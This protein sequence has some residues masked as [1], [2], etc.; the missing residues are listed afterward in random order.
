MLECTLPDDVEIIDDSNWQNFVVPNDG[1]CSE[2]GLLLDADRGFEGVGSDLVR[3]VPPELVIPEREWPE[4]I[5]RQER[6]KSSLQHL[7]T[8]AGPIWLNQSTSWYC[9]FYTV[10]HNLMLLRLVQGERPIR[11]SPESGAGPIK[12]YRKQGGMTTEGMRWVAEH[13]IADT[14]AWPWENHHQ[15]NNRRYFAASRENAKLH[16]VPGWWRCRTFEE[17]FSLLLRNI[18][19]SD[20]Y[21]WMGHAMCSIRGVRQSNGNYAI[22]DLDSYARNGMFNTKL[23]TNRRQAIGSDAIAPALVLPSEV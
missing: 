18:P 23:L 15:A 13:G 6:T 4:W 2:T 17:K 9:W 5:E 3:P 8:A 21:L 22:L 14:T 11:L 7:A 19:V 1:R 12:N 16:R 20:A 10:T